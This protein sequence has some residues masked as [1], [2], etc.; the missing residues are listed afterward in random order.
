[1]AMEI[2]KAAAT[3]L[4][5]LFKWR[6]TSESVVPDSTLNLLCNALR[7]L[8]FSL[9]SDAGVEKGK[10]GRRDEEEEEEDV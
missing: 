9:D 7:P 10:R 8:P 4:S 2:S 5:I 1:M 6:N 3:L